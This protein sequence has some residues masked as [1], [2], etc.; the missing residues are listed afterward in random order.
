MRTRAHNRTLTNLLLGIGAFA[1]GIVAQRY[2]GIVLPAAKPMDG[3]LVYAVVAC[4]F[5]VAVLRTPRPPGLPVSF[6]LANLDPD[7]QRYGL[8]TALGLSSAAAVLWL[9]T[10]FGNGVESGL[11]W[12]LYLASISLFVA[13]VY[14]FAPSG[15]CV[16]Q[17]RRLQR[18]EWIALFA[19]IAIGLCFRLYRFA[20]LPNGLWYDEAD[21]GLSARRILSDPNYRPVYVRSTNL[22]A[23]FLYLVALSFRLLGD[24]MHAIRAVAVLFGMLT[25]V[26]AYFCG[27]EL[28]SAGRGRY[29]GLI[30]AFLLAVSRWD[31]NWSRI[32]M[33]GVTLPFFELWVVATL[34]R[35][36]R[37]GRP[38]AF[39]WTGIALGLGFCFYSP[40][41][42]FPAILGGFGLF[43]LLHWLA[44]IRNARP[45]WTRGQL[46]RHAL[47]TWA[48]PALLL[49][50]GTLIA[51]APV[52]Q[53][54]VRKPKVFWDRAKRVSVF[55][56]PNVQARPVAALL[57]SA[58]WHLLMFNYRGDPNGRH[59]LPGAPMLDR[60]CAVL[61][62]L[63][64]LICIAR[65]DRPRSVLL[66][67]WLLV[68]L[69]G[70][71]LSTW[72]EAPQS[73][74]SI[75]SLPAIYAMAC[76]PME[77]LAD[78]W[79]RV[80]PKAEASRSHRKF[81]KGPL[82]TIAI[83]L[84]V[85]I[86]LENAVT[87]F[88]FWARDFASWAAFNPAETR[89]AQDIVQYQDR[90]ELRFDPLLTAHLT[91]R[92][93]APDYAV[94]HHFD[95]AAVF[96]LVSTSQE[97]VLL[98]VGP[99]AGAVRAQARALYPDVQIATF[100]HPVSGNPVLYKLTFARE[101]IDATRGLDARYVPLQDENATV[102]ARVDD[103]I[104]FSYDMSPPRAY[105]FQASWT[106]GLLAP[107][108]GVY[109]L[110]VD[111]PDEC[112][113]ALDGQ[114]AMTGSGPMSRQIVMAQGV[115]ALYLDCQVATASSVRLS[116][117]K[118]GDAELHPVPPD[119]L[120]R[121]AWPVRGLVGRFYRSDDW[122]GE[123]AL[124]RIDRQVAYY[125]H[126]L[127]LPRPYTVEWTGRLIV[128]SV[129]LYEL[130]VKAISSASLYVDGVPLI[131]HTAPGELRTE[132]VFL[133]SGVHDLTVR[134]LD[135]QA[136]SQVYLY[137]RP[138]DGNRERIPSDVLLLPPEG[139]WWPVP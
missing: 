1:L 60:L 10:L 91:T 83:I 121:A 109:V 136:H 72:F 108:Y 120:H 46:G 56:D 30:L 123:P 79:R 84:L 6:K 69:T 23:H 9:L 58:S 48:I 73:L 65:W 86:G 67:W 68:P 11:G 104:D 98:F 8:A 13:A 71:I 15:G 47:D 4:L 64:A 41:R 59:N 124:V 129:G 132:D 106:G 102:L 50:M 138:P 32:G 29:F 31:V 103:Q 97:G 33:H 90:Y 125:F 127:S 39:A 55:R 130:G 111:A 7:P 101:S 81:P 40:F 139:A 116:W 128:P 49:I 26:A 27:R 70:G 19:I 25:I 5:T 18:W 74:R 53:F 42:I 36:L 16:D 63:G 45:A 35:G 131:E 107:T 119:V 34:L 21:N 110:Y 76:L 114:T 117:Q 17:E 51:V 105:P 37:T 3:L 57:E 89:M 112:F 54:A 94:Y 134:Y 52:A 122:T 14:A 38:T 93:L 137:W 82:A 24:S 77:W 96:P 12:L 20:E 133:D 135:N 88:Y 43:W 113:L 92:Y 78:E 62:V 28:F 115:H 66:M 95:P 61:L 44:R 22:P 80:F 87:Y 99:D 100:V 118:P 85:A 75:G 126:F 2:F